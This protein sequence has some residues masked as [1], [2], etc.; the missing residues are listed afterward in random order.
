MGAHASFATLLSENVVADISIGAEQMWGYMENPY[1]FV[2]VGSAQ[3]TLWI[4]ESVP[5]RR[6]RAATRARL[7]WALDPSILTTGSYRLHM[8]DWGVFG[9]TV[10]AQV[11]FDLG[12]TWLITARSRFYMQ[13]G[14]S[15]YSG[16]YEP[17]PDLPQHRTRD[18]ELAHTWNLSGGLRVERE[19]FIFEGAS[20]RA[21]I[22]GD[23]RHHRYFDTPSLRERTSFTVGIGLT[24]ER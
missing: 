23:V 3:E 11:A 6:F 21:D 8:D 16:S 12:A 9:N 2:P 13:R 19:L 24:M 4:T 15:F 22:R 10:D 1:R 17:I 20:F 18:R 14:A 7:R 5:D